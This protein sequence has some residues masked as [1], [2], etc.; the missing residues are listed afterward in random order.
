MPKFDTPEAI[1]ANIEPGVG[2]VTIVASNR[3]DTVVEI[4][5]TNPDNESDTD[6]AARTTVDFAGNTLTIR[7]SKINPLVGPNK[8]TGS[9]DVTVELP[10]GSH[11]HGKTGM[12]DLTATGRLG[13][14]SYKTGLGDVQFETAATLSVKSG[15][16]NVVGNRMTGK[17][18]I[19]TAGRIHIAELG[20]GG[21][22]NNSNGVTVVGAARGPL[23]VRSANG[24]ITVEEAADDVE[25]KTANGAVRV[26]DAVRGSLTLETAMGEIEVGIREGSAAWLDVK[27]KFGRVRS[28]MTASGA[29]DERA[30]KVEIH[31]NTAFG[32]VTVRRA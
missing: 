20:D 2:S 27:T 15:T 17:A 26:L 10:A 21:V 29:P 11:I 24:D 16:G 23:K 12:G 3:V 1:T 22:L 8:K 9:I 6:A 18:T 7:G 4:R 14:V 31:A 25:A 19:T 13:D 5:P 28:E 32:D 30:D